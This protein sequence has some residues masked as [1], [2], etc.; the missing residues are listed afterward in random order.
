MVGFTKHSEVQ[1]TLTNNPSNYTQVDI[2]FFK[3]WTLLNVDLDKGFDI[4]VISCIS[5]GATHSDLF[6]VEGNN[7]Q[8]VF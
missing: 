4:L 8:G 7:L 2:S 3:D 1:P 5:T 6:V